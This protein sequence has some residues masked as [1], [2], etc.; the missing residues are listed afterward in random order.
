MVVAV[1]EFCG[2]KYD[3]QF[4]RANGTCKK[5]N[6]VAA[7]YKTNGSGKTKKE[8]YDTTVGTA[9]KNRP[10]TISCS[11][12]PFSSKRVQAQ[13]EF[14]GK[15]YET[16]PNTIN[17]SG[18]AA[19]KSCAGIAAIY[20]GGNKRQFLD[21]MEAA[22]Q[23]KVES[24]IGTVDAELTKSKF[25]VDVKSI[26]WWSKDKV[27]I[28]C[29]FC[30]QITYTSMIYLVKNHGVVSCPYCVRRKTAKTICER[31][32]VESVVDIPSVK[33]NLSNPSTE[34][35]VESVLIDHGV[36]FIRNYSIGP[37]SFDFFIPLSKTL[38]ECQGDF[39]HNFKE[40]GYRGTTRDA[41]KA[42]YVK[43][44]TGFELV[45][46]WE[47]EIHLGRIKTILSRFL[48]GKPDKF[49]LKDLQ[50]SRIDNSEANKFLSQHHYIGGL[51]SAK[52]FG[53]KAS[54]KLVAVGSFGP[55]TRQTTAP[56]LSKHMSMNI[57]HGEIL[58]LKRF[59]IIT[60][61]QQKNAASYLLKRFVKAAATDK[62]K[63]VIGF[64]DSSV[65]HS[66]GIYKAAGWVEL[67]K[68]SNS[69]HYLDA[70]TKKAIHKKTVYE[71]ASNLKMKE[72]EFAAQ[73]GLIKVKELPKTAWAKLV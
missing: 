73:A 4:R 9:L 31:Y 29:Y 18:Q 23:E 41:A 24:V 69:Y 25:G 28:K 55:T 49:E 58:E 36:A 35:L 30:N 27:A 34:R 20:N 67:W 70:A 52:H 26:R 66:G 53:A 47:H 57:R 32:G 51:R 50:I 33:T 40:N 44:H 22:N 6:S 59:C 5:C 37:Y 71:R 64:S 10:L 65:G 39:F 60:G 17:R 42:T 1:C 63:V 15:N 54:G 56:K 43:R 8:F 19:C 7:S 14:C 2:N 3:T 16:T 21:R 13:C 45:S 62:T 68:T 61:S 46:I 48:T 11:S 72:S 38:I 12:S